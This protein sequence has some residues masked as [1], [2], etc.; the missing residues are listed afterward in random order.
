M[1]QG[2]QQRFILASGVVVVVVGI[3]I[4]GNLVPGNTEKA[5]GDGDTQTQGS[6]APAS[7]HA[8]ASS[9]DVQAV[10]AALDKGDRIDALFA[11]TDSSMVQMTPL[12]LAAAGGHAAMIEALIERDAQLDTAR[13]GG[14][15]AI[16]FAAR[17]GNEDAL[18]AFLNAGA[19]LDAKTER[20][21]GPL[22]FAAQSGSGRC[23]SIL[24]DAQ[25]DVGA[26][27]EA[28]I[29]PLMIA[30]SEGSKDAVLAL[31][32]G[33]ADPNATDKSGN[34]ALNRVGGSDP[35]SQDVASILRDAMRP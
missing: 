6:T 11:G 9:G 3:I 4:A 33:G 32:N 16:M 15:T 26:L 17:S 8:A 2:N 34:S 21:R 5:E 14:M 10:I 12:M 30:A 27:D 13:I 28:E 1:A 29:T 22:F 19:S 25:M 23:V 24:L 31:L 18:L 35:Q 20:S 7:L